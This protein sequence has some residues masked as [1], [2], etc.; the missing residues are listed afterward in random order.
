V[1]EI[2]AAIQAGSIDA[3]VLSQPTTLL[4]KKAGLRE[5]VDLG[6]VGIEY[7]GSCIVSTKKFVRENRSVTK[8]FLR[9][10]LEGARR[11]LSDKLFA[12]RVIGK[13]TR[14]TSPEVIE[15]TY[16][17]FARYVQPFPM[18]TTAG[19][20]LVLDQMVK[21]EPKAAGVNP[22]SLIDTTILFELRG[23][24]SLLPLR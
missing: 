17:D 2:F 10:Y 16:Q 5:L 11:T 14:V 13:F 18:P 4:A 6:N 9:A 19:V 15:A 3:G 8:D 24:G 23:E 22:D 7:P 20:K 1:P 12:G 21:S